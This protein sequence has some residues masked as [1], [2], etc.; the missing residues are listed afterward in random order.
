MVAFDP[1]TTLYGESDG[2]VD[3]HS[4]MTSKNNYNNSSNPSYTSS[5][6]NYASSYSNSC[7]S[8]NKSN[9]HRPES[10]V[11]DSLNATCYRLGSV[12]QD[13]FFC[14]W[15][16]KDDYLRQSY[17]RPRSSTIVS[18]RKASASNNHNSTTVN[19]APSSNNSCNKTNSLKDDKDSSSNSFASKFASLNFGDKKDKNSSADS[20]KHK[21]SLSSGGRNS[22]NNISARSKEA[23]NATSKTSTATNNCSSVDVKGAFFRD[24]TIYFSC[25]KLRGRDIHL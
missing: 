1:Y 14:L 3:I 23:R 2:L 8:N 21:R 6:K 20:D 7:E 11:S 16:L 13:T 18:G 4:V 12:S 10:V 5:S 22:T 9:R 15:D 25:C 19:S 24:C 17:S